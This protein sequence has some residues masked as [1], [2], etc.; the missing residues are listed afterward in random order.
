MVLWLRTGEDASLRLGVVTS[1]KVGPA[2]DRARARRLLREVFRR[3]RSQLKGDYD[4]ILIGR[5][6]ILR[7]T[8]TAIV[9]DL[10]DLTQKAGLQ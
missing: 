1:K 4:V 6:S 2:V 5:A 10:L 9:D 7:A 8:W 3:H